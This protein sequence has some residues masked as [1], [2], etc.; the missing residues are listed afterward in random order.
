MRIKFNS[1]SFLACFLLLISCLSAS[2]E[3]CNN[4]Q[5]RIEPNKSCTITLKS[6]AAKDDK[7]PFVRIHVAN[8]QLFAKDS[9]KVEIGDQQ[10]DLNDLSDGLLV[11]PKQDNYTFTVITSADQ[12]E[13]KIAK[14]ELLS[15]K[16][17]LSIAE[18]STFKIFIKAGVNLN[19]K[20]ITLSNKDET[21]S[22]LLSTD[23]IG[24]SADKN[25]LD[26]QD[27]L[28]GN[29]SINLEFK[30]DSKNDNLFNFNIL[31]AAKSCSGER[32]IT[33]KT[34]SVDLKTIDK[35]SVAS[36]A[37]YTCVYFVKNSIENGNLELDKIDLKTVGSFDTLLIKDGLKLTSNDLINSKI[38]DATKYLNQLDKT[39]S[40]SSG[41]L[42][43][44]SSSLL[45][46]KYDQSTVVIKKSSVQKF[47]KEGK[48]TLKPE[49]DST[50][51]FSVVDGKYPY[52]LINKNSSLKLDKTVLKVYDCLDL[53]HQPLLT[54]N[55]NET[56]N[57]ELWSKTNLIVLK[58]VS[59]SITELEVN[60]QSKTVNCDLMS[61]NPSTF[62]LDYNDNLFGQSCNFYFKPNHYLNRSVTFNIASLVL[63]KGGILQLKNV[64]SDKVIFYHLQNDNNDLQKNNLNELI[65]AASDSYVLTY[66]VSQTSI[67][68]LLLQASFAYNGCETVRLFSLNKDQPTRSITSN[69]YP[70][71][72][73]FTLATEFD[74]I[75][76]DSF[77]FVSF[78]K[79][80]LRDKDQ[81]VLT[82]NNTKSYA[83]KDKYYDDFITGSFNTSS[84]L[85]VRFSNQ[86]STFSD[87]IGG[88]YRSGYKLDFERIDCMLTYDSKANTL[89]T[90]NYP[91]KMDATKCISVIDLGTNSQNHYFNT[92]IQIGEDG[93]E[94][95][96]ITIY[97]DNTVSRKIGL[98]TY[99]YNET[100]Y[101][102]SKTINLNLT[103]TKFI[104]VIEP[105][106]A[107]QKQMNG[108]QLTVKP[109]EGNKTSTCDDGRRYLLDSLKC[110]YVV[111]CHDGS[112]EKNCTPNA[113]HWPDQRTVY[114]YSG[115]SGWVI[116]LV[117]IPLSML[118]GVAIYLHGPR[119][120]QRVRGSQ[121]REFNTFSDNA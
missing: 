102:N 54:F 15:S 6:T 87:L 29:S 98:L 121:Y 86:L 27:Y 103:S 31:K 107:Q 77:I 17:H 63:G 55:E 61:E 49:K 26:D 111:E 66:S 57:N 118:S 12:G 76:S 117:I 44:L 3:E 88:E 52:L 74:S 99:L 53:S 60:L 116:T 20:A 43:I 97:D 21:T 11:L 7:D 56:V 89:T 78:D 39:I 16:S 113:D 109:I 119:L 51:I 90:P 82:G 94:L 41:L 104:V 42:V 83:E 64:T 100:V 69:H 101:K 95:A 71:N 37:T 47:N 80:D 58:F 38:Q 40:S 28:T 120:L 108:F 79:F 8:K 105:A 93:N 4:Y 19:G 50:Y 72:Y 85:L 68:K 32:Q 9:L 18:L 35:N 106:T 81:L 14:L 33:D 13:R 92:T 70:S 1:I 24:I 34:T 59:S 67:H 96:N 110:N 2:A 36:K 75:N 48:V 62:V 10:T 23:S 22:V 114:V 25:N 46:A 65:L 30:I 115:L 73:P 112:D 5:S 91:K 45:P 84:T